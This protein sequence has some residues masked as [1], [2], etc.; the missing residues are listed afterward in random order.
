MND[1]KKDQEFT[2]EENFRVEFIGGISK[3]TM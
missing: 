2:E 1:F 3:M